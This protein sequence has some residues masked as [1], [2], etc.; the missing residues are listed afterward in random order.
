LQPFLRQHFKKLPLIIAFTQLIVLHLIASMAVS[1]SALA[2]Y[3]QTIR[4]RLA[5]NPIV[6]RR[7]L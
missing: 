1:C 4:A 6:V 2:Q 3:F 5:A 7:L